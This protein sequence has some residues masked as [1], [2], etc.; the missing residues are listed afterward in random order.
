MWDRH[1]TR[2]A[3]G[4]V[5]GRFWLSTSRRYGRLCASDVG[6]HGARSAGHA[7]GACTDRACSSA[8]ADLGSRDCAGG[9]RTPGQP[10][11]ATAPGQS[12]GAQRCCCPVR[13]NDITT[14]TSGG[15]GRIW[16]Q[17]RDSPD[18]EAQGHHRSSGCYSIVP[19]AFFC[20]RRA[21]RR[22]AKALPG[23]EPQH[24]RA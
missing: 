23:P 6:S 20:T 5:T 4:R 15:F 16:R 14:F 11:A 7:A 9:R 17:R 21:R 18:H 3:C 19:G 2:S 24:C 1:A 22:C 10:A 8:L 13:P 12:T